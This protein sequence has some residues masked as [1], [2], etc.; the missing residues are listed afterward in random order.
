MI[1]GILSNQK[2]IIAN[3]KLGELDGEFT[4]EVMDGTQARRFSTRDSSIG[5][6]SLKL[7][8]PPRRTTKAYKKHPRDHSVS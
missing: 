4:F 7:V 1:K 5:G 8:V 2:I 3:N 6:G